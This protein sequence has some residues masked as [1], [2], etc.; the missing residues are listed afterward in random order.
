MKTSYMAGRHLGDVV[1]VVNGSRVN[2][3]LKEAFGYIEAVYFESILFS[4]L[5]SR[6]GNY[7]ARFTRRNTEFGIL[8]PS[9]R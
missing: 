4:H 6:T 1:L 5:F 2:D 8:V 3:S 9:K 7:V